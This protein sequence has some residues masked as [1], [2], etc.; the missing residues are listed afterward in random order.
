MDG[1]GGVYAIRSDGSNYFNVKPIGNIL[2]ASYASVIE[3]SDC[4]LYGVSYEGGNFDYGVIFRVA[5][6][7]SHFEIIHDFDEISGSLPYYQSSLLEAS[8]GW[9]YGVASEGGDFNRGVV[10]KIQKDGTGYSVLHHFKGSDITNGSTPL[11]GV[12]ECDDG[13]LYGGTEL[14]GANDR[15][16]LYKIAKDGTGFTIIHDFN[17]TDGS[18]IYTNVFQASNGMLYGGTWEGGPDEEG[19]LFR[20]N[21]DGTGFEKLRDFFFGTPTSGED[22]WGN[23][24]ECPDGYIY[25]TT[26]EGG[27]HDDGLIYK[28][29][30]DGSG[31]TIL[32]HFENAISGDGPNGLALG[33][34]GF[35]YGTT[36]TG[37]TNDDGL[38]YKIA[39]DGTGFEII[40]HMLKDRDGE[41]SEASF[42]IGSDGFIYMTTVSGGLGADG[43]L[44][45]ISQ[46]GAT[47][48]T[49]VHFGEEPKASGG[50]MMGSDGYV[51]GLEAGERDP[52]PEEGFIFKMLPDG[53][54]CSRIYSFGNVANDGEDP[55]GVLIEGS[56][57]FLYGVTKNG[58]TN[59]FGTIFKIAK[60]G[61]GY[62]TIYHFSA[63]YLQESGVI[64]GSDGFLYGNAGDIVYKIAKNGSGF[65]TFSNGGGGADAT[66]RLIE[67]PSD[68]FLYG[69]TR[70]GSNTGDGTIFKVAKDGTGLTI[71][72]H[73]NDPLDAFPVAGLIEASDGALYG[74]TVNGGTHDEGMIFKINKD[75]TGYTA[76]HH[77]DGADGR[78]PETE[79]TE[80]SSGK[81]F[82]TSLFDDPLGSGNVYCINKNGTGYSVLHEFDTEVHDNASRPIG[83]LLIVPNPLSEPD[84]P[85]EVCSC[86]LPT[87]M[88]NQDIGNTGGV[89]GEACYEDGQYMVEASG[90]KI[91]GLVDGIHYVYL[92]YQG[93]VDIIAR[94]NWIKNS[95]N[96]EAGVMLRETLAPGSPEVS[97]VVNGKK[98]ASLYERT[99]S[100]GATV[101]KAIKTTRRRL[102]SWLRLSRTGNSVLAYYSR[103][104]GNW[105]YVGNATLSAAGGYYVGLATTTSKTGKARNY[106]LDN[107]SVGGVPYRLAD[108]QA[109]ALQVQAFPNPFSDRL[110]LDISTA[111][112]ETAEVL[113]INQLGQVVK[114]ESL[115][116]M[117][118]ELQH[119]LDLSQLSAGVYFLRVRAGEEVT[120][121]KVV[122][123]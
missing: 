35:L 6:D 58:G 116:L 82:G 109:D 36:N 22:P 81:L 117:E 102:N 39:K 96:E 88:A 121:V 107:V 57:G 65:T 64:E 25:G 73:F 12:I 37:G 34:D 92:P 78:S 26:Y 53:S 103:N 76:I 115:T 50:L 66:G 45:K 14:G 30:L 99:T 122:K 62:S 40:H 33:E 10:F 48:A 9:L 105:E 55:A 4:F 15:G 98:R 123:E 63:D 54:D 119:A 17:G 20:I 86:E 46:D 19:V 113:M 91:A 61:S 32:H 59:G 13:L 71:L 77:F 67:C 44:F 68:G 52:V 70:R 60:D 38:V 94:V 11:G 111:N 89:E 106:T 31:F 18:I 47:F 84:P 112:A 3:G 74:T 41:N 80:G 28:M 2:D 120:T 23:R 97:L 21:K 108:M 85:V 72:H 5:P 69:T 42:I 75:G 29:K 104:G 1:P 93:D 7:G 90:D 24:V 79:L 100:G 43:T 83:R 27:T 56:D 49:I 95:L 87:G 51:Y 16:I 114:R 8:D 101:T 110:S 118:G